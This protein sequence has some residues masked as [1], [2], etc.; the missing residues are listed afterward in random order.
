L[1]NYKRYGSFLNDS[2]FD[3]DEHT[4]IIRQISKL[5]REGVCVGATYYNSCAI[6]LEI[7]LT[8]ENHQKLTLRQF[9]KV[10]IELLDVNDHS[11]IFRVSSIPYRVAISELA[12]VGSGV[13]LPLA[14]DKDVGKYGIQQY[15]LENF[16]TDHEK[17]FELDAQKTL[18]NDAIVGLV[19]RVI[20]TLDRE[21]EDC[22]SLI[23]KVVDGGNPSL[24]AE[25]LVEI[26]ILDFNDNSPKFE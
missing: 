20:S 14:E 23:I 12:P 17:L 7:F 16:S 10:T 24:S 15:Q 2:F 9:L 4:G 19:L 3:V 6:S 11:P 13:S 1:L 18:N 5:D 25:L 22:Y 8:T 21:K 26:T